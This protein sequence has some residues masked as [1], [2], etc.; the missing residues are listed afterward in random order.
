Y[1]SVLVSLQVMPVE[2]SLLLARLQSPSDVPI[3]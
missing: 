2:G 3:Q 1:S